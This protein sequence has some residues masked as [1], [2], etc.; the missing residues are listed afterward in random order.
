MLV[1]ANTEGATL[2]LLCER[3]KYYYW[4]VEGTIATVR[5]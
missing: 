2:S 5:Q 4:L 3:E 1:A